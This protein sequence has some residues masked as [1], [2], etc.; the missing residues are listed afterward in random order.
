MSGMLAPSLRSR[1]SLWL[2]EWRSA[3]LAAMTFL[4][5]R[6]SLL[7]NNS[8]KHNNYSYHTFGLWWYCMSAPNGYVS[9]SR[10]GLHYAFFL[11]IQI[12]V[13]SK[14]TPPSIVA[15]R[16]I[17]PLAVDM[18]PSNMLFWLRTPRRHWRPILG[19]HPLSVLGKASRIAARRGWDGFR[20]M[21]DMRH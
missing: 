5:P 3:E 13:V 11:I 14:G 1:R 17:G 10:D 8:N 4:V 21:R 18:D 2:S 20:G 15:S 9:L 7:Y 19:L 12:I 6:V 16:E